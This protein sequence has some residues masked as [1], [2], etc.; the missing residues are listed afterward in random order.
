MENMDFMTVMRKMTDIKKEKTDYYDS[1]IYA[2]IDDVDMYEEADG[3]MA[4][5]VKDRNVLRVSFASNNPETLADVLSR[6][7]SFSGIEV[8]CP[9]IN[10]KTK[11]AILSAGYRQK[12][13][14]LRG[15][16][17]NLAE[18]LEEVGRGKYSDVNINDYVQEAS[19]ADAEDIYSYIHDVFDD[20]GDHLET[21]DEVVEDIKNG[22]YHINRTDGS[23][24]AIVKSIIEGRKVN[25]EYIANRGPSVLAHSLYLYALR[26]AAE[27]GVNVAY[28][29]I[30][31]D[32]DRSIA[33]HSR[34]GIVQDGIRNYVFQKE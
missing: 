28:N 22:R 23:L 29:W 20:L 4:L 17:K 9:E 11:S 18:T 2:K 33:F 14:Y 6:F 12:F 24:N 16:N 5:G 30:R 7:P 10:E 26:E 8:I 27:Q 19:V 13:I 34:F 15:I 3:T 32:N 1:N 31:E 21:Y 25:M